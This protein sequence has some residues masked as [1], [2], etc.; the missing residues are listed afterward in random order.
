MPKRKATPTLTEDTLKR[1]KSKDPNLVSPPSNG[2]R[3]ISASLLLS[4]SPSTC[5]ASDFSA[6]EFE[7]NL[8]KVVLVP[9]E[10]YSMESYMFM[11]F[12][13]SR[14]KDLWERY[15]SDPYYEDDCLLEFAVEWLTHNPDNAMD[16]SD[17]WFDAMQA[18]GIE[19]T[20]QGAI[21]NIE[22]Q[23][24]RLTQDLLSWIVETIQ[25]NY[26]ALESMD[27]TI[28]K[29]LNADEESA[30]VPVLRGGEGS[31]DEP[32]VPENY[33]VLYKS[34][35]MSRTK[36][37]FD[38]E[39]NIN[40]IFAL[41]DPRSDFSST[42]TALYFTPQQWVAD[43][44]ARYALHRAKIPEVRTLE[45]HVPNEHFDKLT[46]WNLDYCDQWRQLIWYSRRGLQYPNEW[47]KDYSRQELIVGP[48]ASNHNKHFN[49]MTS[50]EG[51]KEGHVF[52]SPDG[53][54]SIQYVWMKER[55][56]DLLNED[57]KGKFFLRQ[58]FPDFKI[59]KKPWLDAPTGEKS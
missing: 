34:L 14:A 29:R 31:P 55:S 15:T 6:I 22:F 9:T 53:E 36:E 56:L 45:L 10:L 48:I 26:D 28:E 59:I 40:L 18:I 13:E 7:E 33:T 51:V 50:W 46:R 25:L 47:R 24:L 27:W 44:Y 11:G 57:V 16:E 5:S 20:L 49:K 17:N 42:R 12:T 32:K 23:N 3:K 4:P 43:K 21:M 41:S 54:V 2:T 38:S 52:K 39:G 37:C 30:S 35:L 58:T 1:I 8:K 19:E